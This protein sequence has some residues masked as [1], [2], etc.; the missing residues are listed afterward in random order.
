M[1]F[2]P[3]PILKHVYTTS[4]TF[5]R[6]KLSVEFL[7]Q[8]EAFFPMLTLNNG[9][10]APRQKLNVTS[11]APGAYVMEITSPAPLISMIAFGRPWTTHH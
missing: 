4:S 5:Q 2:L 8:G 11:L 9:Q 10:I 3:D 1:C 6:A 7:N